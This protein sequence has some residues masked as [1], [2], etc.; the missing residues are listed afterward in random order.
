[1]R[2]TVGS[3]ALKALEHSN[4]TTDPI[5]IQREAQ[6]SWSDSIA[7]AVENGKNYINGDFFVEINTKKEKI[8]SQT[9]I[10]PGTGIP[11]QFSNVLRNYFYP[12]RSC[13]TPTWD[14]TLYRYHAVSGALEF[15]W[16]VPSKDTCNLFMNNILEIVPAERDLLKFIMDFEDGT[17]LTLAKKINREIEGRDG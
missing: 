11:H 4:G 3:L 14:Q 5:E 6:K 7:E 2:E 13:P 12:R 8:F 17:L 1:M 9:I 16:V 10:D 15:L